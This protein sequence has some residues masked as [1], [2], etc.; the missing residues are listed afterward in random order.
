[1]KIESGDR[2]L[3]LGCLYGQHLFFR[4]CD[5]ID[6]CV[7]GLVARPDRHMVKIYKNY[8]LFISRVKGLS[9]L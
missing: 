6:E 2:K 8:F 9:C 5:H 1:M 7:M 4:G 3:S